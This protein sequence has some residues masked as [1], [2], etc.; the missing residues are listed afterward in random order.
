MSLISGNCAEIVEKSAS[1]PPSQKKK[2]SDKTLWKRNI[3]KQKLQKENS[4]KKQNES[5]SR[6]KL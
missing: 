4:M 1:N 5:Q 3:R 6:P 2:I